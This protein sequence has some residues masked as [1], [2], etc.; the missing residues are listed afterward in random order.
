MQ[1]KALL[2]WAVK[3]LTLSRRDLDLQYGDMQ[4][5]AR[6]EAMERRMGDSLLRWLGL[7]RPPERRVRHKVWRRQLTESAR[8]LKLGADRARRGMELEML[9]GTEVYRAAAGEELEKDEEGEGGVREDWGAGDWI[10]GAG[11]DD[12]SGGHDRGRSTARG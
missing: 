3:E 6:R 10:A 4:D 11:G 7:D 8:Q 12:R 2:E 9:D 5:W 1:A